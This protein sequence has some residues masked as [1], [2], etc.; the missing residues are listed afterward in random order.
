MYCNEN[1]RA[2]LSENLINLSKINEL[3][4]SWCM[5]PV[6]GGGEEAAVE[7]FLGTIFHKTY[8]PV[9]TWV[10]VRVWIRH[11]L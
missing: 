7:D 5:H 4:N 11:P 3:K 6:E 2:E 8:F 1:T 10:V 9:E